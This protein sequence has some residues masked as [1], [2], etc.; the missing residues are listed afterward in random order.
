MLPRLALDTPTVALR[1]LAVFGG[2]DDVFEPPPPQPATASAARS[3][4]APAAGKVM[5]LPCF[6]DIAPFECAFDHETAS[7][8]RRWPGI[9]GTGRWRVPLT[10]DLGSLLAGRRVGRSPRRPGHSRAR[11][12]AHEIVP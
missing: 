12:W 9:A 7:S 10:S 6:I 8:S 11:W 5:D 4:R 3:S 1:P 2:A